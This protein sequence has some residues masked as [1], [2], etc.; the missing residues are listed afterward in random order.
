MRIRAYLLRAFEPEE[1]EVV[2]DGHLHV[3]HAGAEDGKGHFSVR[4]VSSRFAGT[5]PLE[6]HRMVFDALSSMMDSEIHAL[7]VSA[8]PPSSTDPENSR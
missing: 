1:L 8:A 6:R 7:R 4:I 2:D 3:G 5:S